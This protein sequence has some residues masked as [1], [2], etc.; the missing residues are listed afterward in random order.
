MKDKPS[1]AEEQARQE[2]IRK[3][4][5]QKEATEDVLVG[6]IIDTSQYESL[7]DIV[8]PTDIAGKLAF[9]LIKTI[10]M[11]INSVCFISK[12]YLVVKINFSQ[13]HYINLSL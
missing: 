10:N 12:N 5:E 4:N 2:A 9:K 6:T 8:P 13:I 11:N 7:F 3:A 1:L